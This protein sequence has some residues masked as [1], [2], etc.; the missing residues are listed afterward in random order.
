MFAGDAEKDRLQSP[1]AEGRSDGATGV[2]VERDL[3]RSRRTAGGQRGNVRQRPQERAEPDAVRSH[4][5]RTL[6]GR[7]AR[8]LVLRPLTFSNLFV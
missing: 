6:A 8:G 7:R 3:G 4:A 1:V 2:P 5:D